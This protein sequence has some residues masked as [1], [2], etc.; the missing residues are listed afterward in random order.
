VLGFKRL[1]EIKR[2][3]G[4]SID[5]LSDPRGVTAGQG[6]AK[7][8][9]ERAALTLFVEKSIEG[10]STKS[11]AASAGVSEGLLYRHF[12]SKA[13]LAQTLMR[14][15]HE[16]LTELVRENM[17][18][19]LDAAVGDIV[20]DYAALAD[21]DW[22]LF[23]YHLLYMHRFPNLAS[24][25]PLRAAAELVAFN[26]AAGRLPSDIVLTSMALGV[27]LQAAHGKLLGA[28]I[29]ALSDHTDSFERAVMAVLED[30]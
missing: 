18:Q 17:D 15:I 3:D 24:D 8:R 1:D 20:R 19:S 14:A 21:D 28:K 22:P 9:I 7:A 16:R 27:V 13:D 26:Q 2:G 25:G 10:V 23:A 6:T 11:I 12:K 30:A 29:G 4:M 5:T